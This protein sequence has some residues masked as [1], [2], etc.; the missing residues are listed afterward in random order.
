VTKKI[1]IIDDMRSEKEVGVPFPN[2]FL[3]KASEPIES[4]LIARTYTLGINALR[5]MGPW[6]VVYLDHDFGDPDGK[7]GYHVICQ[8]EEWAFDYKFDLLP[9]DLICVSSNG[10]GRLNI[11][12]GWR[13]I[14]DRLPELLSEYYK[15]YRDSQKRGYE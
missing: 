12:S 3:E 14:K 6:D 4:V 11:E 1:L 10:S 8:M 15:M 2:A 13:S 7:T 5:F 9:K